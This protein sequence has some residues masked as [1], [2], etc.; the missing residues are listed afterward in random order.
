MLV[1][2][3]QCDTF[4]RGKGKH[5][6]NGTQSA[7]SLALSVTHVNDPLHTL[8]RN[9]FYFQFKTHTIGPDGVLEGTDRLGF[10]GA[11]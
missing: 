7:N 9:T 8:S 1:F 4:L 5:V 11:I 2:F 6:F 3:A 10:F